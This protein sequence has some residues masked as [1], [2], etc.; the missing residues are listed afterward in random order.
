MFMFDP[1]QGTY[2]GVV[3]RMLY[4]SVIDAYGFFV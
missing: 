3:N 1:F 4:C 2:N